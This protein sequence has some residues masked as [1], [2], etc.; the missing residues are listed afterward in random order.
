MYLSGIGDNSSVAV[1][2]TG[3]DRMTTGYS[4]STMHVDPTTGMDYASEAAQPA[5]TVVVQPASGLSPMLIFAAL[6]L[7]AWYGYKQGWF[8]EILQSMGVSE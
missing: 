1:P 6:A 5:V 2:I 3:S 7:V 8:T 4:P